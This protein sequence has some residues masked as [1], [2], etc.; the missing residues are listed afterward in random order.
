MPRQRSGIAQR[1]AGRTSRGARSCT[2]LDVSR[3][4]YD[5]RC[6]DPSCRS[7][8]TAAIEIDCHVQ[9]Q[10]SI[11]QPQETCFILSHLF[12]LSHTFPEFPHVLPADCRVQS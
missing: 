4:V 11:A 12:D 1:H 8:V 2:T 6:F 9:L 7:L 10:C 5:G 3:L